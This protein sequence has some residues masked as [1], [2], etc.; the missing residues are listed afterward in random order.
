MSLSIAQ[1]KTFTKEYKENVIQSLSKLMNDY[2]VFPEVAKLTQE[3]L[4]TQLLD[5][6]FDQ[7][8]NNETFAAALTIKKMV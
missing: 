7:F 3:H 6:Y 1:D 4:K 5:G 8:K 2:Y